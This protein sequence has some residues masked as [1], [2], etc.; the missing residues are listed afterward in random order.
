MARNAYIKTFDKIIAEHFFKNTNIPNPKSDK[1][2]I[3]YLESRKAFSKTAYYYLGIMQDSFITG[4]SQEDAYRYFNEGKGDLFSDYMIFKDYYLKNKYSIPISKIAQAATP[5]YDGLK[6]FANKKVPEAQYLLYDLLSL[7]ISIYNDRKL[8]LK[9]LNK[10]CKSFHKKALYEHAIL[11]LRSEIKL[12]IKKSYKEL[13]L[14]SDLGCFDA[15][16]TLISQLKNNTKIKGV[17]SNIEQL[18]EKVVYKDPQAAYELAIKKIDSSSKDYLKILSYLDFAQKNGVL[19]D[20]FKFLETYFN[21]YLDNKSSNKPYEEYLN[22]SMDILAKPECYSNV[23]CLNKL[24]Y[25]Y[26]SEDKY[27]NKEKALEVTERIFDLSPN[28]EQAKYLYDVYKTYELTEEVQRKINNCL[29]FIYSNGVIENKNMFREYF[30]IYKRSDNS[31]KDSLLELRKC[32]SFDPAYYFIESA[33][34]YDSINFKKEAKKLFDKAINLNDIDSDQYTRIAEFYFN[35]KEY[36][37]ANHFYDLA[38]KNGDDKAAFHLAL[39]YDKG[40][41]AP[42]N[43][44]KALEYYKFASLKGNHIADYFISQIYLKLGDTSKFIEWL[45]TGVAYQDHTC[46]FALANVLFEGKLVHQNYEKAFEHFLASAKSG[47]ADAIYMVGYMM[48]NGL[49]ITKNVD[50]AMEIYE[51]A[52]NKGCNK[53][54]FELAKHFVEVLNN[55]KGIM[56]Y[57]ECLK[58]GLVEASPKLGKI[59]FD[60]V[61]VKKDYKLA[62]N[63]FEAGIKK[64]DPLSYYYMGLMYENGLKVSQ[65]FKKAKTYFDKAYMLDVKNAQYHLGYV[66]FKMKKYKECY[67]NIYNSLSEDNPY[68]Y[69]ILAYLNKKK[70]IENANDNDAKYYA[71][72][73]YNNN[74]K[75]AK[76]FIK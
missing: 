23:S 46:E 45:Q 36:D 57:K 35:N 9:Y 21:I 13:Q 15:T 42:M 70:L 66:L 14:S 10:A 34:L 54:L 74:I 43:K 52:Y 53:P 33:I 59:Y 47:N 61:L 26:S 39:A 5:L 1:D 16:K 71:E 65:N 64:N 73:A 25:I 49:G 11:G 63:Y 29:V 50:R 75:E 55:P 4:T 12:S 68:G 58:L 6:F 60:G 22:Y 31:V 18:E 44:E 69:Y 7:G 24:K 19:V 72:L 37:K 3:D 27:I 40:E 51:E 76:K 28:M 8:A 41:T 56:Y 20:D 67:S 30:E 17:E 38:Y 48:Y 32:Q 2:I 62:Y